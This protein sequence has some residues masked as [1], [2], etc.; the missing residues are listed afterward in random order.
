MHNQREAF[1]EGSAGDGS[2]AFTVDDPEFVEELYLPNIGP[3]PSPEVA[4]QREYSLLPLRQFRERI[5]VTKVEA[6]VAMDT[7]D[8]TVP[9]SEPLTAPETTNDYH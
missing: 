4:R 6:A 8:D 9:A 2:R 7:T 5:V 3:F 1:N